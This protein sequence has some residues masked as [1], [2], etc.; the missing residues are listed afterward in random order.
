MT[1]LN[2][3]DG[4]TDESSSSEDEEYDNAKTPDERDEL[5]CKRLAMKNIQDC[6]DNGKDS[7]NISNLRLSKFPDILFSDSAQHI[8]SIDC[9]SNSITEL[10]DNLCDL[11]T[12]RY[13][14]CSGNLLT[15]LPD[16]LP[17]N[18]HMFNC[19]NNKITKLPDKLPHW[20]NMLAFSNNLVSKLPD[21]L[22]PSI[23]FIYFENNQVT[24]LPDPFPA[25]WK[26]SYFKNNPYLHITKE[27]AQRFRW[28]VVDHI[29]TGI[30]ETPDYTKY[31]IVLQTGWRV[32][33]RRLHL[34]HLKSLRD[35]ATEFLLRP[36]NY[37]YTILKNSNKHL[38]M[39]T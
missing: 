37:L 11:S 24:K 16:K 26:I 35:H 19:S 36:G 3:S 14:N 34:R 39:N 32:R 31:A 2:Q 30:K 1:E 21:D 25:W 29:P 23:E 27:V 20:L 7:V 5:I 33:K 22:P 12:L 18:L 38:F 10:P 13:F 15:K 8:S 28:I 4:D 9:S 17:A 6:I